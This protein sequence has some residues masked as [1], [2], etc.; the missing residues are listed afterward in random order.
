VEKVI[1]SWSSNF[2]KYAYDAR[3]NRTK[4]AAGL[5]SP[6]APARAETMFAYDSLDRIISFTDP[7]G[8]KE[9]YRYD[10]GGNLLSSTDRNGRTCQYAYDG[11]NRI[12]KKQIIYN[13][14][15]E[16]AEYSYDLLGHQTQMKDARG[17]TSYEYDSLSRLNKI[18]QDK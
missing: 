5:S 3:G 6:H 12:V 13:G 4:V 16:T 17:V 18:R 11:L 10:P 8:K 14:R 1:N 15:P 7:P 2:V 9:T